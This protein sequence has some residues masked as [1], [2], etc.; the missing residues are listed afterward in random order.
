MTAIIFHIPHAS[1]VI[2]P[3]AAAS[4]S[5]PAAEIEKELLV[6][7]DHYTDLLFAGCVGPDDIVIR[8][9]VSRLAVDVERFEDD[10][11]E[12][13]SAR[14]MGAVYMS[15]H[16]RT[17]LR[18][19]L[20]NHESLIE[21]YY[22]P[23]HRRLTEAVSSHQQRFGRAIILDCHSFPEHAQPYEPDQTLVRPQI[24]IG[25]DGFHTPEAM[26]L[27]LEASYR[28]AGYEVAR[29]TPFV[30]SI[31][32]LEAYG[33]DRNVLSAMIELRRDTYMD[34]RT[35]ALRDDFWRIVETNNRSVAELR[36]DLNGA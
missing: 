3:D 16:D 12:P 10:A 28:Q 19:N 8:N 18:A 32:P 5:I 11:D 33:R 27:S 21:R 14:G 22:Q 1:N 17:T 36:G 26:A 15:R 30:G 25:A 4:I 35:G 29:N 9:P 13:M 6:M 34:E 23:H 7:T 2:P 24:C 31:V 20:S